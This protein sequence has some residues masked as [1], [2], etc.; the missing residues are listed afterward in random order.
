M[1]DAPPSPYL[2][3]LFLRL[4]GKE[5]LVVGAGT[6][7]ERKIQDLVDSGARVRVVAR[8]ATSAVAKLAAD[9]RIALSLRAFEE[10]DVD[11]AWFVV[12]ATADPDVQARACARADRARVFALAV[13]DPPNGTAYS[14]SV[15]RRGPLTIAIS[16]TGE[17]PALARLLREVLEQALPAD[18]WVEAARALR[19]K[20]KAEGTPM[21]SRFAELVRA[22]KTRAG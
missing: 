8:E 3:P 5:V 17:A 13:D 9:G 15:I 2:L 11:G 1:P 20:W 21:T 7:A 16:S 18:D 14:A 6:V 22:F 19:E 10:A 4:A 12:A